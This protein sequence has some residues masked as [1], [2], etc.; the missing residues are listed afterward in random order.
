[1]NIHILSDNAFKGTIV[2]QALPSLHGGRRVTW[3]S[4]YSSFTD[5]L[6]LT[7]PEAEFK[8]FDP[9]FKFKPRL[10]HGWFHLNL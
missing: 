8:E 1:M 9:R 2:N 7:Y 5:D 10:K 4:A 6:E 3:N